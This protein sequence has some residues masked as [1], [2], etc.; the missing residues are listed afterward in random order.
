MDKYLKEDY[1]KKAKV[2][3]VVAT[4]KEYEMPDDIM[5]IP[6][7]VGAEGKVDENGKQLDLGFQMDN[8][9]DN[10]SEMNP[11]FCE[12]TGLYWIWKN[13]RADYKGL[14]HYRRH[15]KGRGGKP[16]TYRE[17][18]PILKDYKVIVPKKRRYYIETL[19]QHYEHNH[20]KE[21]LDTA[22]DILLEEYP[23]YENAY[24]KAMNR[25]W[26][27]MFNMMIMR[28]DLLNEYCEWLFDIL[29]KLTDKLNAEGDK[30]LTSFENRFPGRISERFFNVWLE[31]QIEIERLKREDIYE[32]PFFYTEKIS[33]I[34]KASTF[35]KAKLLHKKP[36][37]SF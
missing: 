26:G 7:H 13:L 1:L 6:L 3:V 19:I 21:E 11:Q 27:Y 9:G 33:K 2:W 25:T 8:V 15:F 12:L 36:Q 23:W 37:K 29:F 16:I 22:R 34:S 18:K 4:H 30:E 14:V 5:Y 35:L 32:I 20:F 31:Y 28:T 17:L 24:N 10:I